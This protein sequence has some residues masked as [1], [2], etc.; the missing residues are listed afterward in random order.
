MSQ[1]TIT[2]IDIPFSRLVGIIF[3]FIIASIPA[4]L[5]AYFVF[6]AVSAVLFMIFGG[7]LIGSGALENWMESLGNPGQI[8]S[9]PAELPEPAA[10]TA[11][12]TAN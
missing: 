10:E 7:V 12:E 8:D 6:A 1:T 11:A 9:S 5:F 3:K 2:N 4:M